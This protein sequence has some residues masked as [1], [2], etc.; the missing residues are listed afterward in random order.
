MSPHNATS[1]KHN[2][3]FEYPTDESDNELDGLMF[4]VQVDSDDGG[5]KLEATP[6]EPE[7]P[8][9]NHNVEPNQ[10]NGQKTRYCSIQ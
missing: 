2:D 6:R 10:A 7:Q 1:V 8:Q 5:D 4:L 9:A 3:K